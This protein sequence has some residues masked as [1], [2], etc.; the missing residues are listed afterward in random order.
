M[1]FFINKSLRVNTPVPFNDTFLKDSVLL[2]GWLKPGTNSG[3][4]FS[5]Y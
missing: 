1:V 4:V 3:L 5:L 2:I